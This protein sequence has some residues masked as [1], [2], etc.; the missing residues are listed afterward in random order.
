MAPTEL[1]S[2]TKR[3]LHELWN[4]ITGVQSKYDFAQALTDASL[5]TV[6]TP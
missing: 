4:M 2:S 6:P 5:F 1:R 3:S